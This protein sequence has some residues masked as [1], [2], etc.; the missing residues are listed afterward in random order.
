MTE[1]KQELEEALAF[2][3]ELYPEYLD[4]I[5][6]GQQVD[7]LLSIFD[8]CKRYQISLLDI[9]SVITKS[10]ESNQSLK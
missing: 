10:I 8:L 3:G 6:F 5:K 9:E 2:I 4:I 1:T 7:V